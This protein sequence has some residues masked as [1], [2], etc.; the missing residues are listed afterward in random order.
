MWPMWPLTLNKIHFLKDTTNQTEVP[1]LPI[2]RSNGKINNYRNVSEKNIF[3]PW[4][5]VIPQK[6]MQYNIP[7]RKALRPKSQSD[8]ERN[9]S[10]RW[11]SATCRE[12]QGR[13]SEPALQYMW[14]ELALSI[15]VATVTDPPCWSLAEVT[16]ADLAWDC[17]E[18]SLNR[19]SPAIANACVMVLG[20]TQ[21]LEEGV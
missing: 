6:D 8:P 12:R 16:G 14:V 18:Y 5:V 20:F 15:C 10:E 3:K 7:L 17:T 19:A 1:N 9:N 13:H 4:L 21:G 11:L 2:S